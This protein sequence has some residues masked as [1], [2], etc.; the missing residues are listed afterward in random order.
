M[1]YCSGCFVEPKC[2]SAVDVIPFRGDGG[3][4]SCLLAAFFTSIFIFRDTTLILRRDGAYELPTL[5]VVEK[6]NTRLSD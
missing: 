4:L 5:Y 1:H 6:G 3:F 2:G